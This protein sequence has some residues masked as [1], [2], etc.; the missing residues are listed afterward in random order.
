MHRVHN[1]TFGCLVLGLIFAICAYIM[2]TEDH[3]VVWSG[4]REARFTRDTTPAIFWIPAIAMG[5]V[6]FACWAV[7]WY[8]HFHRRLVGAPGIFVG[9]LS[10][11]EIILLSV[12]ALVLL[13][14]WLARSFV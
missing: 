13:A 1:V 7:A 6:A 2:A 8:L 5:L 4:D 3:L 14:A 12:G 10:R 9:R 11:L